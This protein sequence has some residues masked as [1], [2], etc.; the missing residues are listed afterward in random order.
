MNK[1]K[2]LPDM[3]GVRIHILAHKMRNLMDKN[4][5]DNN[6]TL[7]QAR[8]LRYIVENN[9]DGQ[10]YQRDMEE[11]FAIKRSSV[12]SILNNMEKAGFINRIQDPEDARAKKLLLTQ[13]GKQMDRQLGDFIEASER[14]L[15]QGMT[16]AEIA[17]MK[18]LLKKAIENIDKG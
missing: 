6:I 12:T 9:T 11:A 1:D 15:T 13:E 18:M 3:M 7:E 16:E 8:T 2:P 5:M 4:L 14:Q 17:L 10:V